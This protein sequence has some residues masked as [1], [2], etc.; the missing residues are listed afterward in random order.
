[1]GYTMK[2]GNSGVKFKELGSSPNKG[3]LLGALGR[4][5]WGRAFGAGGGGFDPSKHPGKE[6][7]PGSDMAPLRKTEKHS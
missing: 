4:L 3:W 2:R 7:A 6:S 1:M 5:N